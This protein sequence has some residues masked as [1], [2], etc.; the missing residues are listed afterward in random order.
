VRLPFQPPLALDDLIAFFGLRAIPGVEDVVDGRYARSVRLP[1]GVAIVSVATDSGDRS[2]GGGRDTGDADG[3]GVVARVRV[4]SADDLDHAVAACRRALD[5]DADPTVIDA[6]LGADPLLAPLVA[7]APG[8]RAPGHVDAAE[9]AVRAV[10]GQQVSLLAARRLAGLL[11]ELCGDPLPE[12]VGNVT[13]AFPTPAAIAEADLDRIGMPGTRRE[14]LRTLARSLADG[15]I[16]LTPDADP[17]EAERRLLEIRGI[18]PWTAAYIRMRGLGD[19][20][21]LLATDLGVR[22]A[23]ARLGV[24]QP[25]A[26]A[27]LA[28]RWSPWGSYAVQHLWASLGAP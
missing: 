11:A 24:D 21:V 22:H 15:D 25:A 17:D 23:L 3:P 7:A 13:T 26:I 9:L 18:G 19:R 2:G 20:D 16:R 14:T 27:V 12:P 5:L 4:D 6:A 10:L 8:R 28:R 1:G